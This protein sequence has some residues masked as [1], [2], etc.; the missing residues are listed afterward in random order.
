MRKAGVSGIGEDF[1]AAVIAQL[2]AIFQNA[3]WTR[4]ISGEVTNHVA[5]RLVTGSVPPR[6]DAVMTAK[7]YVSVRKFARGSVVGG[8]AD[9]TTRRYGND[10]FH[11]GLGE[12]PNF[13]LEGEVIENAGVLGARALA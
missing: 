12:V 6:K 3:R 8:K 9:V 1:G 13:D 11:T 5:P 2:D 10:T 4:V 7:D